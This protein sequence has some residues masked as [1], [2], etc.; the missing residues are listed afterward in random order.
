MVKPYRDPEIA[1]QSRLEEAAVAVVLVALVA[2][3]VVAASSSSSRRHRPQPARTQ[4]VILEV[5]AAC[6]RAKPS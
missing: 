5:P 4:H 6:G 3:L 2:A 1:S